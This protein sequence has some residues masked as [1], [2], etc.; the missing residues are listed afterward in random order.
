[1]PVRATK[2]FKIDRR[3]FGKFG[4]FDPWLDVDSKLFVDPTLLEACTILEF[5]GTRDRVLGH[6]EAIFRLVLAA[7][8]GDAL[9]RAAI[10]RVAF[11][12]MPGMALGYSANSTNGGGIGVELAASIVGTAKEIIAAGVQDPIIFE[13]VGL[14]EKN[15]GPDRISD[16]TCRILGSRIHTW[17]AAPCAGSF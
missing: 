3:K 4:A 16:M 2:H 10:E 9:W 13:M 7:K 8:H 1:M 12:E 14:F 6:Y 15:I 5:V 11:H 17:R